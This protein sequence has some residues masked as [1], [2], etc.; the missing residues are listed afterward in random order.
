[1]R[2]TDGMHMDLVTKDDL[3]HAI[4]EKMNVPH[5]AAA[6]R[7]EVILDIFG[8][9]HQVIDN[10]LEPEDRQL[11]YSLQETGILTTRSEETLLWN[12]QEWRTHYWLVRVPRVREL[13]EVGR[14]RVSSP[15]EGAETETV[16]TGLPDQVWTRVK[17]R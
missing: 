8:Y 15:L 16:Y 4:R 6:E 10:V 2:G 13:A 7:A 9:D 1:M 12:G 17:D 5:E 3:T 11:F 14:A